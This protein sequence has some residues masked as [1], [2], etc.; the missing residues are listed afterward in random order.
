M[1]R[2]LREVLEGL[3]PAALSEL[4]FVRTL[5]DGPLRHRVEAAGLGFV[6][7][8]HGPPS[9]FAALDDA[10]RVSAY[11]IAQEAVNNA[12]RHA[13]A[14]RIAVHLRV[15]WRAGDV[16]LAL[17][18]HDDGCGLPADAHTG[19]GRRGMRDRALM[20]GGEVKVRAHR[21]GGTQVHALLRQKRG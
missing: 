11:R 12:L 16:L 15:G 6:F 4:G 19:N 21:A 2:A 1:R 8:A 9:L 20:L 7:Y 18:V 3:H 14:G 17:R 5:G 10:V 13:D